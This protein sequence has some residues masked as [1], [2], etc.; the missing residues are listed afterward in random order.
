[1]P[2]ARVMVLAI[3]SLLA[4]MTISVSGLDLAENIII[5]RVDA[6]GGPDLQPCGPNS[7]FNKVAGENCC[8]PDR[9]LIP[10]VTPICASGL[11]A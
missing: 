9:K 1:M 8:V 5:P 6:C 7:C 4:F 10:A 3:L 11:I 2:S